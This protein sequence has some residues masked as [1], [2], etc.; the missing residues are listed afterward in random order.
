LLL[1][2]KGQSYTYISF[3]LL[4]LEHTNQFYKLI[5]MKYPS[6]IILAILLSIASAFPA[7]NLEAE[8]ALGTPTIREIEGTPIEEAA[9]YQTNTGNY[10]NNSGGD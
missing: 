4:P 3:S 5:I 8:S 10:S 7:V 2:G 1:S 6:T 9:E